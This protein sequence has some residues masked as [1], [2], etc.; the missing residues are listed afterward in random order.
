VLD[1]IAVGYETFYAAA[2]V[3]SSV[4][5]V[6]L[7]GLFVLS[8]SL[9]PQEIHPPR[10][11]S[12]VSR[13]ASTTPKPRQKQ[14]RHQVGARQPNIAKSRAANIQTG[15]A[16]AQNDFEPLPSE[17]LGGARSAL[18]PAP[19]RPSGR[20]IEQHPRRVKTKRA[21]IKAAKA[22]PERGR[23][24]ITHLGQSGGRVTPFDAFASVPQR[25]GTRLFA[26][27]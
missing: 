16:S 6:L 14:N 26:N 17:I 24:K 4:G 27:W 21:V 5:L 2:E 8:Y 7:I 9:E 19:H 18:E 11:A 10:V 22:V 15:S 12:T 23:A 13:V 3:L 1:N 20:P 25:A